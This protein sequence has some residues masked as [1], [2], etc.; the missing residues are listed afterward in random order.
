MTGDSGVRFPPPLVF[1]GFGLFGAT[2]DRL[3]ALERS[4]LPAWIAWTLAGI[5]MAIG[6]IL[7]ASALRRFREA[8]TP[9]EPWKAT[10]AITRSG[11]YGRTRNPMYIGMACAHLAVAIGLQSVG[12]LAALLPALAVIDRFVVR[13]EEAYLLERFGDEYASFRDQVRRWI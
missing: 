11:I 5:V 12:I 9:P 2:A 13:R 1:L 8:K 7:V 4:P 3:L 10:S 6:V